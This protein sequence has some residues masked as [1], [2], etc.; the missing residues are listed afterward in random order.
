MSSTITRTKFITKSN[1]VGAVPFE[2]DVYELDTPEMA[3]EA[4]ELSYRQHLE[5]FG[6]LDVQ[7]DGTAFEAIINGSKVIVE[8]AL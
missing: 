4:F 8:L 2:S 7:R 5:M 3:T 6:D 1:G